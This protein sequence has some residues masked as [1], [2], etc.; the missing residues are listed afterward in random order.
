M[1]TRSIYNGE[2]VSVLHHGNEY[3]VPKVHRIVGILFK[4]RTRTDLTAVFQMSSVSCIVLF[5][6]ECSF[7]TCSE[8][9][10]SGV[11]VGDFYR[12]D[13]VSLPLCD[14]SDGSKITSSVRA[15]YSSYVNSTQ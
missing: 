2:F 4:Y 13:A 8:R 7:F 3:T 10:H 12:V 6:S 9:Q 1:S 14:T 15:R 5:A 11:I